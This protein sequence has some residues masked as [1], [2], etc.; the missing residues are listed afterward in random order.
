M[1]CGCAKSND[2]CASCAQGLIF[3]DDWVQCQRYSHKSP[4][5]EPR[6]VRGQV[7]QYGDGTVRTKQ[8]ARCTEWEP[9]TP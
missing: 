2:G 7:W 1:A 4:R 5:V 9:R 6:M 3:V 8:D